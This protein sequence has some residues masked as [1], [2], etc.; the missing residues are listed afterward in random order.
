MAP[1]SHRTATSALGHSEYRDPPRE[2]RSE[3]AHEERGGA[4]G[5][6]V[7]TAVDGRG[8]DLRH[9]FQRRTRV[10]VRRLERQVES[11]CLWIDRL[12][13]A[14]PAYD[15]HRDRCAGLVCTGRPAVRWTGRRTTICR[16]FG[17]FR[18]LVLRRPRVAADLRRD[19]PGT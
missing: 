19:L 8:T 7:H 6:T 15:A 1:W 17:K 9:R 10:R 16:C 2:C 18:L 14:R 11:G 12:A 5:F 3:S 13:P 4:G